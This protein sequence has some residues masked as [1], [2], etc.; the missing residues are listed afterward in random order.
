MTCPNCNHHLSE[1][2]VL[3]AYG[4]I[5]SKRR[6]RKSGGPKRKLSKRQRAAIKTASP[7][8]SARSL[9][10][11]YRVSTDTIRRVLEGKQ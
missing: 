10:Q 1:S 9:A 7:I 2:D 6:K 4:S 5:M 11:M 8:M 3:S